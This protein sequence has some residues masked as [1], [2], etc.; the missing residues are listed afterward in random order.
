MLKMV[1]MV[2][3]EIWR[4]LFGRRYSEFEEF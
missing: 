1:A 3:D 4:E 2:S